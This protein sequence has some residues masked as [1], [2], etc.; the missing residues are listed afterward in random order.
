MALLDAELDFP[1][2]G[3]VAVTPIQSAPYEYDPLL[4]PNATG[5][6]IE[7]LRKSRTSMILQEAVRPLQDIETALWELLAR[8]LDIDAAG[9]V[10]LDR[11][12]SYVVIARRD[13]WDDATYRNRIRAR[14]LQHTSEGRVE[15][16]I[17]IALLLLEVTGPGQVEIREHLG[18]ASM[19]AYI[20]KVLDA[21]DAEDLRVALHAAK[22]GGVGMHVVFAQ[23]ANVAIGGDVGGA[24]TGGTGGD[25]SVD[26]AS[27]PASV[28]LGADV[29]KTGK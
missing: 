8:L 10:H 5:E 11:I 3:E 21:V 28:G 16:L 12:G 20:A 6:L 14:I 18:P 15:D 29:L 19:T 1:L 22:A 23:S 9:G 4:I 17:G 13:G 25:A 7:I 2:D 27:Q 24:V 26:A